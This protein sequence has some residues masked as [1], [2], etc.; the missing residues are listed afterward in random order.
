MAHRE[1]KQPEEATF[2]GFYS[3]LFGG[4]AIGSFILLLLGLTGTG[5]YTIEMSVTA[6][7]FITVVTFYYGAKL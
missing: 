5:I 6:V 3:L 7:M 2:V 4:W 1:P